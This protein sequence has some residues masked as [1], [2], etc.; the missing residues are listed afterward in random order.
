MPPAHLR[1]RVHGSPHIDT[2]LQIGEKSVE[3]IQKSL[4][5]IGRSVS[6]FENVLDF[7]CGSGRTLFNFH[8]KFPKLRLFGTD[9]D[10]QAISWCRENLNFAKFNVN[11]AHAMLEYP[12]ATFDFVYAVSVFTHLDENY[13]DQW[14][15]E[16]HRITKP[17]G[18]ILL[19]FHGEY[20]WQ[21]LEKNE[22]KELKEKGFL[23]RKPYLLKGILPDW[24]QTAFHSEKY[25][26]EHYSKYFEVVDFIP[27]GLINHHDVGIFKNKNK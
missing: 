11:K 21:H 4:E 14:L 12:P 19:T 7:G 15:K 13:Q 20:C 23:F 6:S 22:I 5:R 17:E 18:I 25:V 3:D 27:R 24:Y 9:I 2:Y 8:K 26:R 16:L 10:S 1:Y